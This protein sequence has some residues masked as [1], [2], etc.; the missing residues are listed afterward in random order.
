MNAPNKKIGTEPGTDL[1]DI[2]PDGSPK[3]AANQQ[4]QCDTGTAQKTPAV[5]WQAGFLSGQH[6]G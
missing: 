4:L 2:W 3:V 1:K 6:M 5:D